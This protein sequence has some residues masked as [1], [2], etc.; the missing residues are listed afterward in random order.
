MPEHKIGCGELW[1]H[2]DEVVAE[3]FALEIPRFTGLVTTRGGGHHYASVL[4]LSDRPGY[5]FEVP[6]WDFCGIERSTCDSLEG[7]KE[8]ISK[9]RPQ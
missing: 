9:F 1:L 2:P 7:A 4:K 5:R 3:V 8:V 6:Q